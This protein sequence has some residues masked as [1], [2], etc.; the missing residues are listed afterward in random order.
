MLCALGIGAG[1]LPW[2]VLKSV[3]YPAWLTQVRGRLSLSVRTVR[4]YGRRKRRAVWMQPLIF[5]LRTCDVTIVLPKRTHKVD[6]GC[7]IYD[8]AGRFIGHCRWTPCWFSLTARDLTVNAMITPMPSMG[9]TVTLT[10]VLCLVHGR[11]LVGIDPT[12]C[13]T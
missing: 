2:V 5:A 6:M 1:D 3:F 9:N 10:G 4:R 13:V 7:R 8:T 11:K 12:T